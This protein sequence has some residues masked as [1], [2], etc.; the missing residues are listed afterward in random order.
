LALLS[1]NS[2]YSWGNNKYGQLGLASDEFESY[3]SP[4]E[5]YY[6]REKIICFLAAGSNHSV[7]L[8]IEGYGYVWGGNDQG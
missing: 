6:F 5:L 3:S 4:K 7:A 2:V 8:S 1:E